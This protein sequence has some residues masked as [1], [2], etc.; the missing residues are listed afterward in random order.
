MPS[1][2][3]ECIRCMRYDDLR[4][5]KTGGHDIDYREIIALGWYLIHEDS[6]SHTVHHVGSPRWHWVGLCPSCNIRDNILGVE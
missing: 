2:P 5:R 6:G 3:A 1:M 4:I